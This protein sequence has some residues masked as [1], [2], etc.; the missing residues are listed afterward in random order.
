MIEEFFIKHCSPTLAGIKT[1]NLFS[2]PFMSKEELSLTI[3]Y[4]NAKFNTKG[5]YI[6]VLR[7]SNNR[8]L[9]FVYRNNLLAEKLQDKDVSIFLAN[10]GYLTSSVPYCM[11]QL[12]EAFFYS[13]SFP[14][15]IGIFLGY[16]LDDVIA[17][18]NHKGKNSKCSGFWKV[19]SNEWEALKQFKRYEK[20]ISIYAKL[21][22]KGKPITKL[23]VAL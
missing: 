10:Y 2:F 15:E 20:C 22:S 1:A 23:T 11:E 19:Y 3:D 14:H 17:F 16:P 7:T 9:I 13:L 21:Y 5:V 4:Y 8:A 6:E 12:K 18:I